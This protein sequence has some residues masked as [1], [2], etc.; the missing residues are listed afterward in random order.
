M[1]VS[2]AVGLDQSI[3]VGVQ[4][5]GGS[6]T[7]P[8]L[9]QDTLYVPLDRR[10]ADKEGIGNRPVG[11][12][13]CEEGDDVALPRREDRHGAGAWLRM[14]GPHGERFLHRVPDRKTVSVRPGRREC[15]L[16]DCVME[17]RNR[18]FVRVLVGWK[19][20]RCPELISQGL[21]GAQETRPAFWLPPCNC[22]LS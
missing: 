12:A 9:R 2:P 7:E 17:G 1:R 16:I 21:L 15:P 19:L 3:A 14:I 4:G 8:E 22:R 13:R 6:G 11:I 10:D 20:N 18:A 5:S